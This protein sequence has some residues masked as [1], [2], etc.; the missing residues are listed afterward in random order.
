MRQVK[1][2]FIT[3]FTSSILFL[4]TSCGDDVC[5]INAFV[6]T[7]VGKYTLSGLITLDDNDTVTVVVNG[8]TISISSQVLGQTFDVEYQPSSGTATVE[9]LSFNEFVIDGHTLTD[10][11]VTSGLCEL[12]GNCDRLFI[13]LSGI[14]IGDGTID[15]DVVG[16]YPLVNQSLSTRNGMIRQ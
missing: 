9:S 5:D 4:T 15:L 14:S 6:G 8:N 10:I 11:S 7:F 2:L 12:S 13:E 1:I 16:G 3:L